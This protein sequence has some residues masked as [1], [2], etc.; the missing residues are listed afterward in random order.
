M[1]K[2]FV[3]YIIRDRGVATW[4]RTSYEGMPMTDIDAVVLIEERIAQDH[5]VDPL[6]VIVVSWQAFEEKTESE[7]C[8]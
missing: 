6:V 8:E 7:G 4:G 2:Y 1:K 5:G 3:S